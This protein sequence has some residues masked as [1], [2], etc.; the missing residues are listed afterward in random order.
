[1]AATAVDCKTRKGITRESG[2]KGR[3]FSPQ[4]LLLSWA[5]DIVISAPIDCHNFNK[6]SYERLGECKHPIIYILESKW[7]LQSINDSTFV[8]HFQ[9]TE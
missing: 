5:L 4:A 1:M 8:F 6:P 9:I 2:R 3:S 7:S